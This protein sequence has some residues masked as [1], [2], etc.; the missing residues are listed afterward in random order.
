MFAPKPHLYVMDA[1]SPD[2]ASPPSYQSYVATHNPR[3]FDEQGNPN[4]IPGGIPWRDPTFGESRRD[5]DPGF[6]RTLWSRFM[7]RW[8]T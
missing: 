1:P 3:E 4:V 8:I 2:G 5:I 6:K 7:D